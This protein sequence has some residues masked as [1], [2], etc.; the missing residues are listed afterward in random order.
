MAPKTGRS[1]SFDAFSMTKDVSSSAGISSGV[2]R[3]KGIFSSAIDDSSTSNID[4]S[5][6][7]GT[8]ARIACATTMIN[9]YTIVK[10][11]LTL[12]SLDSVDWILLSKSREISSLLATIGA[13]QA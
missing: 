11:N 8:T 4:F 9:F 13:E 2:F 1:T 10:N 7:T 3:T 5:R 6:T 12:C